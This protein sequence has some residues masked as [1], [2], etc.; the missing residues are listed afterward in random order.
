MILEMRGRLP[1]DWYDE[2]GELT[3]EGQ[4]HCT[5]FRDLL[6]KYGIQIQVVRYN[7]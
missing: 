6:A 2:Q 5:L 7:A 1:L 4:D 3:Q